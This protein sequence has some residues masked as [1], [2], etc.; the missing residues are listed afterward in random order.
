MPHAPPATHRLLLAQVVSVL[1]Y[2]NEQD[3]VR[4][5]LLEH[6]EQVDLFVVVESPLTHTG[7]PK[8]LHF[9]EHLCGVFGPFTPKLL[10][11]VLNNTA[12]LGGMQD[13]WAREHASRVGRCD[14]RKHCELCNLMLGCMSLEWAC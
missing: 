3:V 14:A 4:F 11:V 9:Q 2:N 5:R 1:P 6:W 7:N 12:E 10:H 13:A 8:P